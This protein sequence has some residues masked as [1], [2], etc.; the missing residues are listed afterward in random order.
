MTDHVSIRPGVGMLSLFPHMKYQ[1]WYAIGEL[2]DNA[3]QSYLTN[4]DRLRDVD[5]TVHPDAPPYRLRVDI[6]ISQ[7]NGG[8]I[9][10]RD[11]AAGISAVD[12]QR[13]FRVAEPPAD[14][15]G[16]SQFGIGLKAAAAWFA[17]DFEVRSTAL[18]ESVIR[19][20]TFDIPEIVATRNEELAVGEE[21]TETTTHW[22]EVRLWNL[23][24]IPKAKTLGKMK[25]YLGSIYRDFLR[26]GDVEI[27]FDGTPI[28]Y[29]QPVVLTA[30]PWN[31]PEVEPVEWRKDLGHPPGVGEAGQGVGWAQGEGSGVAGRLRPAVSR[32]GGAGSGRQRV[33]ARRRLRAVQQLSDSASVR[34]AGHERLRRHLHQGCPRL[35]RRGAGVRRAP[36]SSI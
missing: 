4:R 30:S 15:S 28:A 19:T 1:P 2:V 25:T 20:V 34:R 29:D 33:Q 8:H 22:T 36:P 18:G 12:F 31:A 6:E 24:R 11:N 27:V 9:E 7:A 32:E 23:N 5:G 21:P 35:V 26:N 14:A 10:V 17:K 16:L 3:I 13:A